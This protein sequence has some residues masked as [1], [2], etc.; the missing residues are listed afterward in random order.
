MYHRA[1]VFPI[2]VSQNGPS[3]CFC[4]GQRLFVLYTIQ[5][6]TDAELV[7]GLAKV[8]VNPTA[9]CTL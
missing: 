3:H 4:V 9:Q 8:R 5:W 1:F 7:C 2:A 6:H